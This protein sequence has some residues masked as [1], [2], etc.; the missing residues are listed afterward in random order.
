M[1]DPLHSRLFFHLPCHRVRGAG[2]PLPNALEALEEREQHEPR[3]FTP[4][5]KLGFSTDQ[6]SP[7]LQVLMPHM[8]PRGPPAIK[9]QFWKAEGSDSPTNQPP[10]PPPHSFQPLLG[11][12][13]L[14]ILSNATRK[15]QRSERKQ[16]PLFLA[17][18]AIS[19]ES[20]SRAGRSSAALSLTKADLFLGGVR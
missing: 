6:P 4:W 12:C 17:A 16:R 20:P 11:Q 14:V 18:G 5:E 8:I 9:T 10:Y 7:C 1:S 19:I 15:P 3:V 13:Y 2:S